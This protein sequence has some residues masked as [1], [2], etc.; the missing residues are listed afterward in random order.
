M[1]IRGSTSALG[2]VA[3]RPVDGDPDR[4]RGEAGADAELASVAAARV[5]DPILDDRLADRAIDHRYSSSP[6]RRILCAIRDCSDQSSMK[7]GEADCE[8]RP[9]DSAKEARSAS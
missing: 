9:P 8:K 3:A 2:H 4:H 7:P 6:R 5:L 1:C